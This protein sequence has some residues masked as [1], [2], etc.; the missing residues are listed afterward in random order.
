MPKLAGMNVAVSQRSQG[1]LRIALLG[2]DV[3][4]SLYPWL[5]DEL[6][7]SAAVQQPRIE[8]IYPE[9]D[10]LPIG[11]VVDGFEFNC[12]ERLFLIGKY[13]VLFTASCRPSFL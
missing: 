1:T 9:K 10:Q 12:Y 11:I 5:I 3:G 2:G 6:P 8:S 7:Y 13:P 4:I